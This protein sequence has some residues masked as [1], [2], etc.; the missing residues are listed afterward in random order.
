M[1]SE[2]TQPK[3]LVSEPELPVLLL[4]M[5]EFYG[6]GALAFDSPTQFAREVVI[7]H[8]RG[9]IAVASDRFV[10]L[11]GSLRI[12][13]HADHALWSD[14]YSREIPAEVL[15]GDLVTVVGCLLT[16]KAQSSVTSAHLS[17]VLERCLGGQEP[18]AA[19]HFYLEKNGAST[20]SGPFP[21]LPR[22][23]LTSRVEQNQQI[24][25]QRKA[26]ALTLLETSKRHLANDEWPG[27]EKK[28]P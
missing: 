1:T 23:W 15:L 16:P 25:E 20:T 21:V 2:E 11:H 17:N 12:M 22:S 4:K 19:S 7:A 27:W 8:S 6:I 10:G 24:F 3:L 14:T 28:E 26:R 13:A 5:F 18:S 9:D